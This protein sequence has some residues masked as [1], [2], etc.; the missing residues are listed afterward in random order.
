MKK[1]FFSSLILALLFSG[2]SDN[3]KIYDAQRSADLHNIGSALLAFYSY[4]KGYPEDAFCISDMLDSNKDGS[5]DFFYGQFTA[6]A[7]VD[8]VDETISVASVYNCSGYV[9][10][11]MKKREG[12]REATSYIVFAKADK[13]ENANINC[14]DFKVTD[15]NTSIDSVKSDESATECMYVTGL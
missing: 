13:A 9:Y 10:V 7:P 2:C 4:N 15:I 1:L 8:P 6:G 12:S 11:P 3:T 5:K 14:S